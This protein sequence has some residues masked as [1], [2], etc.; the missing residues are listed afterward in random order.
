MHLDVIELR[1]FYCTTPLGAQVRRVVRAKLRALWPDLHGLNLVGFGFAAPF[2]APFAEEAQR[3]LCLMPAQQG[4][5]RWPAEGPNLAALVEET[6]WPLP[7]GFAERIIVAHGLEG[8][9]RAAA[10]LEEIWRVLAPGGRVIFLVAN[11]SGLWAR[12]DATPFGYG[13][14]Y[15]ISQL[16]RVLAESRFSPER[17]EGVLYLPP[18]HRRFWL[19]L[20]PA[21]ER[22]GQRFG[23]E[24]LAGL[25]VVEASKLVYV[26]PRPG[27]KVRADDPLR[28]LEGLKPAPK[29]RPATGRTGRSA[30]EG[31]L[32]KARATG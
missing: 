3:T 4:V 22:I 27:S 14:P 28:V 20:A 31:A 11:R 7:S 1:R 21:I 6:L 9:E 2:L 23:P 13:R 25:A 8:C 16:E 10:L 18:S 30:A 12:S 17:H 15:S 26:A 24:R 19:R 32:C 5:C 29:P